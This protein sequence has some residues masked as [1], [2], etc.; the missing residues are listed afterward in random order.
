MSSS[1]LEDVEFIKLIIKSREACAKENYIKALEITED[2]IFVHKED[3]DSWFLHILEGQ[4]FLKLEGNT[5]NPDVGFAY[6]LASVECFS[7]DVMLSRPCAMGFYNLAKQLGSVSYYKKCVEKSKQALAVTYPENT[8]PVARSML[9]ELKKDLEK[10]F[11]TLIRDAERKI[12]GAKTSPLS[13]EPKVWEPKKEL[14]KYWMGLDIKIKRDFMKVSIA[15]LKSF[16]EGVYYREG[17][18]VLEKVLTS[19]REDR[20]WTFWMCETKCLKKFSSAEECKNHLEQQHAADFKN[21]SKKDLVQRIGKDWARKISVGAWEPVDAVAAVEMIK[22]RLADVKSFAPKNG[23]SKEWPLAADEDRSMLLKEIKLLLVSYCDHK[24]LPSSIREWLMRF[25]VQY[26][27]KLEV[28]GQSLIDSHLVETPQSIC[29]LESHE[30]NQILD[31]L[32]TINCKRIDG[33]DLICR[34]VDSFLDHTRVK[35]K[36]DFDPQFS[37]LLLDR[38]LL[39]CKDVPFD[40]EGI[41]NVFDPNVHYAKA[42]AQGDDI[43]SWLTDYNSVDKIFA[44]PIREH[45]FGIWVAVLKAVQFTFRSLGTKYAKKFLVLDYDAALTVVE[46]LC[47]S[48][49]EGERIFRKISGIDMHLFYVI[50]VKRES[51]KIHSLPIFSCGQYE[52]LSDDIALKSIH[53]LKSV[54]THKVL[55]LDSKILLIDNSRITLLNNLTRLSAFD[56]RTY[57]LRLL[58]PFLLSEIVN[59]ESK[60]KSDAAEAYL[61]LEEEKTSRSK[62]KKY[63][64]NKR[65]STS[66]SS[67]LDKT[68]DHEPSV[69]LEPRASSPSLKIVKED[70]MELEGALSSERGRL[71]ISS[72]SGIQ[73]EATKDDPDMRNIPG[74]DLLSEHLESAPGEVAA[75]YNSAL[76]MTL[77]LI[78]YLFTFL[79]SLISS[80]KYMVLQALLNIKIL[81]EDL[82]HNMQLF[83]NHLEEQVPSALQNLFTAFVSEVIKNEGVYSCLLSDLLVSVEEMFSMVYVE[84]LSDADAAE[85]VV[86]I[87]EFWHCWKYRERES[88]VTRLFTLEENERMSCI[89]CRSKPNYPE[90][91]SQGIVVAAHS[92]RDLKCTFGNIKFVD[93]LKVTRM[94][95]KML[96]DIKSGGCGMK[97]IVHHIISRCPPI[98]TIVLEWEKNETEKEVSETTKALEWEIDISRMYDGLEPNTNYRLVSVVGCSEV[99]E[100]HICIAY[101]KNRWVNLRRESLVGED[102]GNWKSVVRFC[103]ER[104]VRPEI[105]FYEAA[106]SMAINI[107]KPSN[108][109]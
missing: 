105:L 55:L 86:A 21:A 67:P 15:K 79:F 6:L 80:Q 2:L 102:I 9:Q 63:K 1:F 92:I 35:E 53:H 49:D 40:D 89:K 108:V 42:P 77:K 45:N 91:R 23:W 99:E 107:E 58:K 22:N 39:K 69:N 31:F 83:Q 29:F 43:I 59:M 3:K 64:S 103:G 54:V 47:M 98:F 97:N 36:I 72:N 78:L 85:V 38:R 70:S 71:E 90:Q 8:S 25:P 56:N 11:K 46:N 34:A 75:R 82:M 66:M 52:I 17:R 48:E 26:L 76:D 101:E 93:I 68:V 7:Q 88:L 33:T 106:G 27:G 104:K 95:C 14:R 73:D 96:C 20:K 61:L 4:M 12:A 41:I 37:F 16:V 19:A 84:K 74:E 28:S 109:V 60:A 57:I 30:L 62:K 5:E 24:I 32:K 10:E 44:R 50:A 87:F 94:E 100:E 18:D 65:N 13:S 81:K 51:P